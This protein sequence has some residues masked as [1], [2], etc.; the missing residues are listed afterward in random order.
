MELGNSEF[1]VNYNERNSV[2]LLNH[3]QGRFNS[4][5]ITGSIILNVSG[6]NYRI[7]KYQK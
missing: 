4:A 3:L 5:N 6:V 7:E 2:S 1:G